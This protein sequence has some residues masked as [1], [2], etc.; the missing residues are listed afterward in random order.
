MAAERLLGDWLGDEREEPLYQN[1]MGQD[2]DAFLDT[3]AYEVLRTANLLCTK[4]RLQ[5]ASE[6]EAIPANSTPWVNLGLNICCCCARCCFL[7]F[8]TPAGY[9]ALVEDGR[10]KFNFHSC[11]VHRVLDPFQRYVRSAQFGDGQIVHGDRNLVVIEQGFIGFALDKG[12]PILL[13]PGMH[14]W[15]SSTIIYRGSFDLNNNVIEMGPLTLV[16]VD[17]GYAAVTEDNGKQKILEGGETYL[18]NHRNWK[19][20]KFVSCKIQTNVMQQIRATSADNVLMSVNATVIWRIT[21]VHIAAKNAAETIKPSGSD[22]VNNVANVSALCNDVLKQAEASLAAFIGGVNYSDQF[23]VA[24][25][26]QSK[27][28]PEFDEGEKGVKTESKTKPKASS[29][30]DVEKIASCC[31]H[32]NKV[33]NTYGVTIISIN[34]VGAAPADNT[35]QTTLAQG[36]VAAAEANKFET[37]ARGKATAALIEAKGLGDAEILRAKGTAEA[38]RIRAEGARGAA[39]TI[40]DSEVAVRLAMVEKTGEALGDKASFFFGSQPQALEGLLVPALAKAA[41]QAPPTK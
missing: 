30:F 36:A 7:T 31:E 40:A 5:S 17:E 35:L 9:V 39:D 33:A 16:T 38:A 28:P 15:K 13:P 41:T 8:E 18:L 22:R 19:F 27:D 6:I 12:Q 34:V 10:G 32:A 3:P 29:L 25:A 11:G 14:Q 2:M 1:T 37:V 21:D 24:A 20:R 4:Y 26:V 23:A